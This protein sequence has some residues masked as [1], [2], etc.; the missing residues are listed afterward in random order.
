MII[1]DSRIF[2]DLVKF[3]FYTNLKKFMKRF[4]KWCF[5]SGS[6]AFGLLILV[7]F[8]LGVI[9]DPF[10]YNIRLSRIYFIFTTLILPACSVLFT[11]LAYIFG[12][13]AL[14]KK[15]KNEEMSLKHII[16]GLIL[17]SIGPLLFLLTFRTT[18][19]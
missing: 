17:A 13:I 7:L 5:R 4:D 8:L 9:Q 12:G 18:E 10:R 6:W 14:Y 3:I 15:H 2:L 1:Y 19:F 16:I 11:I